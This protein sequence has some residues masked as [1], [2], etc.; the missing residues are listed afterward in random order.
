MSEISHTKRSAFFIASL[1][2][3]T[4][5]LAPPQLAHASADRRASSEDQEIART[6]FQ[7]YLQRHKNVRLDTVRSEISSTATALIVRFASSETCRSGFCTT[8]LLIYSKESESWEVAFERHV[9]D[10]RIIKK[11]GPAGLY[12]LKADDVVWEWSGG[13]AYYPVISS[14]GEPFSTLKNRAPN[15]ISERFSEIL[16]SGEWL[17]YHPYSGK[18][19]YKISA[20]KVPAN[21]ATSIWFAYAYAPGECGDTGCPSALFQ[22]TADGPTALWLGASDGEGAT[23]AEAASGGWRDILVTTRQGY[24]GLKYGAGRYKESYT[25]YQSSYTPSP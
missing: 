15:R 21:P 2:A 25:S 10:L 1:M 9:K 11:P 5:V 16:H 14:L 22:D 4:Q 20:S 17:K 18:S 12:F 8:A 3:C 24:K 6:T 23:A 13:P 19:D 7:S